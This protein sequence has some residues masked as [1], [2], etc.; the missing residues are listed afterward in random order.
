MSTPRFTVTFERDIV[1]YT[2]DKPTNEEGITWE[3]PRGQPLIYLQIARMLETTSSGGI[4]Q[5]EQVPSTNE[6]VWQFP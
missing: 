4:Y 1:H 2:S 6:L 5:E 3:R